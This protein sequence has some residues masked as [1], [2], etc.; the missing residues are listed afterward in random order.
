MYDYRLQYNVR[1]NVFSMKGVALEMFADTKLERWR[2]S[3]VA[4][5]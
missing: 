2:H 3:E 4:F 5:T 1:V